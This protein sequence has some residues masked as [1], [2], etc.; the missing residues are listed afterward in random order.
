MIRY[1][2]CFFLLLFLSPATHALFINE[3]H[4]DN[5]G[6]DVGEGIELAG[7]AGTDLAG[8]SLVFY[9]GGNG[10]VYRTVNL[11]GMLANQSN[12]VGTQFF[13]ISGLQ[14]GGPDGVALVDAASSVVQFLSYEGVFTAADGAAAGLASSDIGIAQDGSDAI[15]QSLQLIGSGASYA[16]FTWALAD[17]SY[18]S[19]NG[20]Q[21]IAPVPLP[22]AMPLL[23]GALG[24]LAGLRRGEHH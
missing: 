16:D 15:G 17:A 19:I 23:L 7:A 5:L 22:A 2:T 21:T 4:Y 3:I 9:N 6:S 12:G 14:N 10:Q 1:A 13:S 11:K 18:G 8:F 20:A 24:L